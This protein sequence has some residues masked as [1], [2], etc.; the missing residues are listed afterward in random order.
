MKG[1]LFFVLLKMSYSVSRQN[2]LFEVNNKN[3]NVCYLGTPLCFAKHFSY[4][5]DFFSVL[6]WQ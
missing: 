6:L 2:H 4:F 3:Q 5:G 1:S